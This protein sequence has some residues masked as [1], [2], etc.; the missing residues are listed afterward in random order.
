MFR[1][2]A[3]LHWY[4]GEG[5]DETEFIECESNINDLISEYESYQFTTIEEKGMKIE[6]EE[7]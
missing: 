5:M 1:R 3:F 6:E 7:T 2:K 4:I